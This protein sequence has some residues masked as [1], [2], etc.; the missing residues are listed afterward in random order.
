M[1]I[2]LVSLYKGDTYPWLHDNP[3]IHTRSLLPL[4]FE[5]VSPA[6]PLKHKTEMAMNI[7]T[8]INLK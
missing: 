4:I 2:S 5:H 7:F 3:R 8:A 1:K 6:S